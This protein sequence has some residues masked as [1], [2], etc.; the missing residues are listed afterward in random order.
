MGRNGEKRRNFVSLACVSSSSRLDIPIIG[1]RRRL[2]PAEIVRSDLADPHRR[3]RTGVG[4]STFQPGLLARRCQVD[5]IGVCSNFNAKTAIPRET[6][7]ANTL[8]VWDEQED[9]M[10]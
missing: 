2:D 7:T 5:D 4:R 9:S 1:K 10:G 8:A 3:R 6:I